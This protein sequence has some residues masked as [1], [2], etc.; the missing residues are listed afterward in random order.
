MDNVFMEIEKLR[1]NCRYYGEKAGKNNA[2]IE[3]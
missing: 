1:K 3:I 2:K